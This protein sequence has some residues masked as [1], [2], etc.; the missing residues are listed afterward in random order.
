MGVIIG[1]AVGALVVLAAILAAV[2]Y[3][4]KFKGPAASKEAMKNKNFKDNPFYDDV[5]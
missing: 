2:V 3:F 1:S 4:V 5:T